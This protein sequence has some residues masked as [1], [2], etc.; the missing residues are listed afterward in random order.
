MDGWTGAPR[1]REKSIAQLVIAHTLSLR[2]TLICFNCERK[3]GKKNEAV[4]KR[5]ST[6]GSSPQ[7]KAQAE[8][9]TPPPHTLSAVLFGLSARS[10]LDYVRHYSKLVSYLA[11]C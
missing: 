3:E 4:R 1:Q 7:T 2:T 5:G 9:E 11:S 8:A 10:S 6:L